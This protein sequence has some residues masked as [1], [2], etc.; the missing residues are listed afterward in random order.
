MKVGVKHRT[1]T[2]KP[3]KP[4][5]DVSRDAWNEEHD[6]DGD[7]IPT[8]K[9]SAE[10]DV[11]TTSG[12][13]T[14]VD[15][16]NM[17]VSVTLTRKSTLLVHFSAEAM[18]ELAGA[19]VFVQAL[20]GAEVITPGGVYFSPV[21]ES[22]GNPAHTHVLDYATYQFNFFKEAVEAGI[23]TVKMQFATSA[24]GGTAHLYKRALVVLA[25]TE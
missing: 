21:I 10:D 3:N 18:N 8:K 17:S 25:L 11:S 19:R 5:F 7:L 15:V 20:V 24:P 6:I 23:Y 22:G 2:A 1:Q 14:F 13:L 12:P 16:P 4:D 9:A